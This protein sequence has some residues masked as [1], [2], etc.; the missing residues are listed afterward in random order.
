M[1]Q[2]EIKFQGL[3]IKTQQ[4]LA[5]L[6][7]ILA[8]ESANSILFF[9]NWSAQ[10][11]LITVYSY[12]KFFE[13]ENARMLQINLLQICLCLEAFGLFK[14]FQFKSIY[15]TITKCYIYMCQNDLTEKKQVLEMKLSFE[16]NQTSFDQ[17]P[18]GPLLMLFLKL[19]TLKEVSNFP[20]QY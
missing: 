6:N 11:H 8:S 1:C 18:A 14:K 7:L 15:N 9:V 12:V 20:L 13:D 16:K 17:N 19:V 4:L 2:G 5:S 3:C 10:A